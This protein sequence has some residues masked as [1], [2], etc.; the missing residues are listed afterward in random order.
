MSSDLDVD[1]FSRVLD[2]EAAD[3]VIYADGE[4]VI[5]FWNAGAE[6]IFECATLGRLR[7]DNANW[8]HQL[9]RWRHPRGAGV[10]QGWDPGL[11]R[12]HGAAV[13]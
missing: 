2:N 1:R 8:Q 7:R 13:S 11:D 4:G 3:A 6:R 9:R 5:R 12:V 10:A